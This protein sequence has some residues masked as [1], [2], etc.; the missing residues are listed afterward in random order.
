MRRIV[1][2]AILKTLTTKIINN[3]LLMIPVARVATS[4]SLLIPRTTTLLMSALLV[5]LLQ[6]FLS[7]IEHQSCLPMNPFAFWKL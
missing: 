1:N 3:R 4:V 6:S 7:S 2:M 5:V